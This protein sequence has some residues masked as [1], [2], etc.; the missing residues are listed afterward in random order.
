MPSSCGHNAV[1]NHLPCRKW[2]SSAPFL[3][4]STLHL[5]RKVITRLG[6]HKTSHP[7]LPFCPSIW[8]PQ[9]WEGVELPWFCISC[10]W[11]ALLGRRLWLSF[12]FHWCFCSWFPHTTSSAALGTPWCT[13]EKNVQVSPKEHERSA[14][15]SSFVA[16]AQNR[17][18]NI[19]TKR[20]DRM[21]VIL[22]GALMGDFLKIQVSLC[23]Q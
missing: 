21:K 23:C 14:G 19:S 9:A 18:W 15:L 12:H 17:K 1:E 20:K 10:N 16:Q 11:D 2:N 6:D 13:S 4:K 7:G 3:N 8:R 5:L 22:L